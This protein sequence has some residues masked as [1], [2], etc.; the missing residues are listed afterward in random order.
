MI[1]AKQ[2]SG[3]PRPRSVAAALPQRIFAPQA[4]R[5]RGL[6]GLRG[7][8]IRA[9]RRP[10]IACLLWRLSAYRARHRG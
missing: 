7:Q 4:P 10:V 5:L 2:T 8:L 9:I 3:R 1:D 6:Q